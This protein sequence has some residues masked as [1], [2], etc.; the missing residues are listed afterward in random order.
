MKRRRSFA[1]ILS[2]FLVAMLATTGVGLALTAA[3]ESI[4][5]SWVAHDLDHQL[6]IDSFLVLLPQFLKAPSASTPLSFLRDD[7]RHFSIALTGCHVE[8][9]VVPEKNKL[10]IESHSDQS[11]ARLREIARSHGLPEDNIKLRPI[12]DDDGKTRLPKF[13][14]FDQIIQPTEFEEIFQWV[15]P[16]AGDKERVTRKTWSDLISFWSNV[17]ESV[18]ALEIETTIAADSRR[19]FV[20]VS[21]TG[22]NLE[23]LYRGGV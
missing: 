14:W 15:F 12:L 17:G 13:V 3:T 7:K 23:V 1:L 4:T 9:E 16:E 22:K 19:W 11:M 6:A 20:V 8:C 18:L 21:T 5:A 10:H 2:I